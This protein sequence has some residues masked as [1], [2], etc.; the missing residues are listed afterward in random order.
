MLIA[1]FSNESLKAYGNVILIHSEV[2]IGPS[3]LEILTTFTNIAPI[4]SSLT[5]RS[6]KKR[7]EIY[8]LVYN[9]TYS[10]LAT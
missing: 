10:T 5:F 4:L 9:V 1:L 6:A 8:Y 3:V 2:I 7:E